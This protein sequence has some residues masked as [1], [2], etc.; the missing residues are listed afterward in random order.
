IARRFTDVSSLE[1]GA[2]VLLAPGV[3]LAAVAG[4]LKP[5]LTG[6]PLTAEEWKAATGHSS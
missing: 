6:P 4:P 5:Q 1:R 3:L 2:H